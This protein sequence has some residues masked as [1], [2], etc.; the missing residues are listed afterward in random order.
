MVET[1]LKTSP[2]GRGEQDAAQLG[3]PCSLETA[4]GQGHQREGTALGYMISKITLCSGSQNFGRECFLG[5]HSPAFQRY[6]W[7]LAFLIN[8]TDSDIRAA[9]EQDFAR[10]QLGKNPITTKNHQNKTKNQQAFWTLTGAEWVR[11][12]SMFPPPARAGMSQGIISIT[13]EPPRLQS[14]H[15]E[16]QGAMLGSSSRHSHILE[17]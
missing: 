14:R 8:E 16:G 3:S 11:T 4:S 17:P 10:I 1:G 9:G 12:S 5:S 7:A 6:R 2:T 15:G 13:E